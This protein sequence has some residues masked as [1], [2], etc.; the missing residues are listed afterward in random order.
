MSGN[1]ELDPALHPA[2]WCEDMDCERCNAAAQAEFDAAAVPRPVADGSCPRCE[3]TGRYNFGACGICDGTGTM[4]AACR[5]ADG[6]EPPDDDREAIQP[7]DYR[8]YDQPRMTP[9][10]QDKAL[11]ACGLPAVNGYWSKPPCPQHKGQFS[12]ECPACN[13]NESTWHALPDTPAIA[14]AGEP[15]DEFERRHGVGELGASE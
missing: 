15:A 13:M 14:L 8:Y 2:D 11:V 3:G 9:E 1:S 4:A 5:S 10:E 7:G 12:L 6:M